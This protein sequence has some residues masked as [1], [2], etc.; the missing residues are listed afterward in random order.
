MNYDTVEVTIDFLIRTFKLKDWQY[1]IEDI[2]EDLAE[3]LKLIGAAKVFEEK[4]VN[5]TVNSM[6]AKLPRDCQHIK[7]LIPINQLY[8][9]SGNFLE[10]DL[11]DGSQIPL[12]YQSMPVDARGYILIPD[13]AE[14]RQALMWYLVRNLTLQGEI[15][16]IGFQMADAEWD[17]R[18]GSARA[19]LNVWSIQDANRAYN[20][21]VR[22]NPLKDQH[23]KGYVEVGQGNTLDRTKHSGRLNDPNI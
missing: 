20:D 18:C 10:I 17:W 8:R 22:L 13:A 21:F 19:A 7:H 4:T 15:T 1:D 16:R 23:D 12:V 5:L 14:V 11:P 9:E 3:A 6:V 2:V